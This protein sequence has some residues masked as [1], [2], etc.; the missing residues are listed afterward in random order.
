MSAN[1]SLGT[2]ELRVMKIEGG[3]K[4]LWQEA[5]GRL[6]RDKLAILGGVAIILLMLIALL[7]AI[8]SPSN[9]DRP[10]ITPHPPNEQ[11]MNGTTAYGMP[12][13]I[14]SYSQ[15][16]TLELAQ[17]VSTET[18]IP[19]SHIYVS[20]DKQFEFKSRDIIKIPP[21]KT[22]VTVMVNPLEPQMAQSPQQLTLV[23]EEKEFPVALK[24][25]QIQH[26]QFFILGTDSNGRD[27][28]SRLIVGSQVSL[29]VGIFAMGLAAII[30]CLLG[31]LSG[32]FGGWVDMLIMRFTDIIMA[33]PSTLLAIVV[34]AILGRRFRFLR[35]DVKGRQRHGNQYHDNNNCD[36]DFV[37][38]S[39]CCVL[40]LCRP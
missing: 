39:I 33:L 1:L 18:T 19:N 22:S 23:P 9:K 20:T 11:Y 34:A 8:P 4:G 38:N 13:P 24:Q 30:G 17:A 21:G 27:V 35:Y 16:M 25:I 14:G 7:S 6:L 29:K 12:L 2:G 10:L 3:G 32:Y 15:K 28:L 31:V 5:F 36:N 26:D 37:H 40:A